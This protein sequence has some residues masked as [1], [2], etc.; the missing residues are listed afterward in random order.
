M[1]K[2]M[3]RGVRAIAGVPGSGGS[4]GRELESATEMDGV[5]GRAGTGSAVGGDGTAS[6]VELR[7]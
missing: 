4:N 7:G 6:L 2:G 1:V 3:R 5:V